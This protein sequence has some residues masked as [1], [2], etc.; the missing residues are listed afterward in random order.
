MVIA[1]GQLLKKKKYKIGNNHDTFADND[2]GVF[3]YCHK[4][5]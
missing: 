5:L 2:F 1:F 4:I 3:T